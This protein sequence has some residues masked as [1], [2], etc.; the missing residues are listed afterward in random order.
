[1]A[2]KKR[3]VDRH[4]LD[5]DQGLSGHKPFGALEEQEGWPMGNAAYDLFNVDFRFRAPPR[6]DFGH[7]LHSFLRRSCA[8]AVVHVVSRIH[9]RTGF[10]G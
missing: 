9:C 3:L 1:M 10:A 5:P 4:V 8:M 2:L 6:F 7:W